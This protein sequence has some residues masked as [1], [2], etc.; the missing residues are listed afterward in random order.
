M[1]AVAQ[2]F[3]GQQPKTVL[4]SGHNTRRDRGRDWLPPF[5]SGLRAPRLGAS[6]ATPGPARR[7]PGQQLGRFTKWLSAPACPLG[8]CARHP[9]HESYALH[10]A[11]W[12]RSTPSLCL[13]PPSPCV[14]ARVPGVLVHALNSL[15]MPL[16]TRSSC[17]CRLRLGDS[18]AS[19]APASRRRYQ[20]LGPCTRKRRARSCPVSLPLAA[21]ATA[22]SPGLLCPAPLR[23]PSRPLTSG[24][25]KSP[26]TPATGPAPQ[27]PPL[28]LH[29]GPRQPLPKARPLV[30]PMIFL[31]CACGFRLIMRAWIGSADR[32]SLNR[33][34]S[35]RL[36]PSR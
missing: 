36:S 2:R 13:S 18:T 27:Q 35:T 33:W 3:V 19:Q 15:P 9:L 32:S 29:H 25:L 23:Q 30:E 34:R 20:H 31:P 22:I 6:D 24:G 16:A 8:R 10:D 14:L 12:R 7:H 17:R 21:P 1:P 4:D 5:V 26:R 28:P 11:S